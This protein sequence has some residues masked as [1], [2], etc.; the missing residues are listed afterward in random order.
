MAV[1]PQAEPESPAEVADAL[2]DAAYLADDSTS[3]IAFLAQRRGKP[4]L[5]EGPAGAGSA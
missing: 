3:L 4:V 5:V 1:T 2:R